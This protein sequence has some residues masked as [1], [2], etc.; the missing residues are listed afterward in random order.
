MVVMYVAC[1]PEGKE[2]LMVEREITELQSQFLRS[3]GETIT[4]LSYP[5]TP[6][7]ELPLEI[8]KHCPDI[9]HIS[10]HGDRNELVIANADGD[11]VPLTAAMLRSFLDLERPPRLVYLNACD[12]KEIAKELVSVVPMAI[13]MTAPVTNRAAR[14]AAL[15]FYD[16]VFSGLAV[17]TAFEASR[18]TIQALHSATA[19]SVLCYGKEVD[20]ALERLYHAPRIVARFW[21]VPAARDESFSIQLG[22]LG[23]PGNT[24]QVVFLTD[25]ESFI[26]T[27]EEIE[28]WYDEG[29]SYSEESE[30]AFDLCRV[31]RTTP[32]RSV[33][34]SQE[35]EDISGDYRLFAIGVTGGGQIFTAS[36]TLCQA[37]QLYFRLA[38]GGTPMSKRAIAELTRNDGTE[39]LMAARKQDAKSQGGR[40]GKKKPEHH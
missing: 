39:G 37:L 28:E 30:L 10:A 25:D 40:K 1:N 26:R 7:E 36:S 34:W 3:A 31:V 22:V 8:G 16:R 24:V 11:A 21:D 9:L 18:A 5:N 2:T 12:S 17:K 14:A 33:V 4:L 20:P 15:V 29:D 38:G 32:V 6:I 19:S 13:G 23:C 35:S 27:T